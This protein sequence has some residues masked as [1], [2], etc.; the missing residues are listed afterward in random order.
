MFRLPY[1]L[2]FIIIPVAASVLYSSIVFA[3]ISKN[4]SS[5][6]W[7]AILILFFELYFTFRLIVLFR[8]YNKV[9]QTVILL[10][11]CMFVCFSILLIKNI[12]SSPVNVIAISG[13]LITAI[14]WFNIMDLFVYPINIKTKTSISP[15]YLIV[16]TLGTKAFLG[17]TGAGILYILLNNLPHYIA[18]IIFCSFLIGYLFIDYFLKKYIRSVGTQDIED[19]EN[20]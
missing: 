18:L 10:L 12:N 3:V 6:L 17:I 14:Y 1:C 4:L 7:D 15:V 19:K 5:I 13:L 8:N 9:K 16:L 2:H 20:S 11:L